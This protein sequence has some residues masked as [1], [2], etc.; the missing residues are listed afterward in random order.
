MG[1]GV[2]KADSRDELRFI[3]NTL[4]MKP[5]FFERYISSSAGKDVRVIVVGD[6]AIACM[7]R[8]SA[9]DF[10]SNIELG[11]RGEKVE[12]SR[13]FEDIAIRA[14]KALGLVYAGVDILYGEGGKPVVCEVNSIA[15]FG[16]IERVSGINVARAYA[17]EIVRLLK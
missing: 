17:E 3:M 1:K 2:Y 4:K 12:L 11:G 9:H 15:F 14:A 6:R 5:H 8:R 13:E 10:R 16:E 7:Q